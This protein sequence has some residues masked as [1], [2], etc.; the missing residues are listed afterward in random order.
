MFG[1]RTVLI[2]LDLLS[3]DDKVR[4]RAVRVAPLIHC[5]DT[6][7]AV[8]AG[9]HGDLPKRSAVLATAISVI[10]VVLSVLARRSLPSR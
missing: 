4:E 1:I 7:G 5:S 3:S 6:I 10:N 9:V 2:G 8:V